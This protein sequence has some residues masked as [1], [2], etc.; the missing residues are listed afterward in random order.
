[1]PAFS[2]LGGYPR[3]SLDSLAYQKRELFEYWSHANCLVTTE[4]YPYFR[5]RMGEHAKADYWTGA[6]AEARAYFDAV[7][8]DVAD[9]GPLA[10]SEVVDAGKAVGS[11]WGWSDGK[12]ALE[13]LWRIGRLAIAGRRRFE[14]LYDLTERVIPRPVL[15]Q[16]VPSGDEARKHLLT[17]AAGALG[18]GT[19]RDLAGYF[20][21]EG[22]WERPHV[23]GKRRR[24]ELPRLVRELVE[25]QRLLSVTVEGWEQPG[26]IL[27]GAAVPSAIHAQAIVSPFDPVMWERPTIKGGHYSERLFGLDYKI[28]IYVP[29]SQRAY[30]YYVL[31]FLYG[32]RFRARV[33]LKADRKSKTLSVPSAYAEKGADKPEVAGA[34]ASEL[35]EL[36]GWLELESVLVGDTGDLALALRRE[37]ARLYA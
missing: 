11:W 14:R 34:L 21:V 10:A 12:E 8:A 33:D 27:P 1:M 6:S 29:A 32:D 26:Y 30:G 13:A 5:W 3:A 9:R 4:L 7:Y 23:Q 19:A 24:S 35:V 2:R 20:H 22:W 28:E 17:L 15:D 25:E 18:V 36:A 37:V 16:P 31:P